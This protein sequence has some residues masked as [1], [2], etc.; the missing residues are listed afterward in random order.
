MLLHILAGIAVIAFIAITWEYVPPP[1][2]R[3]VLWIRDGSV[4]VGKGRITAALK[5]QLDEIVADEKLKRGWIAIRS[6]QRLRFSRG[7]SPAVRQRIRNAIVN[8]YLD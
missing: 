3:V 7:L 1:W 4:R 8:R 6:D 2:A 5:E